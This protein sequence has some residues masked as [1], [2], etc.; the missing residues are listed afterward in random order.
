MRARLDF[1]GT[2]VQLRTLC[3]LA[4]R[5]KCRRLIVNASDVRTSTRYDGE[6][7]ACVV[8]SLR[9]WMGGMPLALDFSHCKVHWYARSAL[10]PLMPHVDKLSVGPQSAVTMRWAPELC[11]LR[12]RHIQLGSL[13]YMVP[14]NL[15]SIGFDACAIKALGRDELR[16]WLAGMPLLNT[17]LFSHVSLYDRHAEAVAEACVAGRWS[18]LEM[19]FAGVG[20]LGAAVI[21]TTVA[22]SPEL[23][24]LSVQGNHIGDAGATMIAQSATKLLHLDLSRC[25]ISADGACA[26]MKELASNKDPVTLR[27]YGNTDG[28][29]FLRLAKS[30]GLVDIEA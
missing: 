11:H 30:D 4:A 26:V 22:R 7:V 12:V 25:G 17:V 14:V 16:T 10:M 9:N 20:E 27:A 18:H 2:N 5:L 8:E 21:A 19:E 13:L 6:L 3:S 29:A 28:S 24:D 23:R 1:T 15:R